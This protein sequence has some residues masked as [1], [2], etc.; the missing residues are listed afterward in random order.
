MWCSLVAATAF[1]FTA[2][3]AVN[4]W[5]TGGPQGGFIRSLAVDPTNAARIYAGTDAGV[6]SSTDGGNNWKAL[7]DG[8]AT[9]PNDFL[10]AVTALTFSSASIPVLYAAAGNR[11]F[12]TTAGASHWTATSAFHSGLG[13]DRIYALVT[14]PANPQ[15]IYAGV[16]GG[17]FKSLD[18]GSSW[19]LS[20][21]GFSC[22]LIYSLAVDPANPSNVYSVTCGGVYKSIDGGATWKYSNPG[23]NPVNVAGVAVDREHP[24]TIYAGTADGVFKSSDGAATWVAMNSGLSFPGPVAITT[25]VIDPS[26]AST[27]YLGMSTG[28]VFKSLDNAAS[29]TAFQA[30]VPDG[31]SALAVAGGAV[32][33]V[34]AGSPR[35]VLRSDDGAVWSSVNSGIQAHNVGAL[36]IDSAVVPAMYTVDASAGTVLKSTDLGASWSSTG[37]VAGGF[38]IA[39]AVDPSVPANVYAGT[40]DGVFKSTDGGSSWAG[41]GAGLPEDFHAGALAIAPSNP[42]TVYA[43]DTRFNSQYKSIDG[44]ASWTFM[45]SRPVRVIAIDPSNASTMYA[46]GGYGIYATGGYGVAKSIDGGA[47]WRDI[48]IGI[49]A[50]VLALAIDPTRPST[51]Y[52]STLDDGVFKS[53][54]GGGTW[55]AVNAGLPDP[56]GL[57]ID[58]L[59]I[60]PSNSSVLYVGTAGSGV[61]RTVSA[62][63]GWSSF[64]DGLNSPIVYALVISANG[65]SL[66]GATLAGVATVEIGSL[67]RRRVV[68]H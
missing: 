7:T 60:D 59:A 40:E 1:S 35:G 49:N 67:P 33:R 65:K 64:N 27:I 5:T 9:S 26:N 31:V 20:T 28:A 11:V 54:D 6:Y 53:V 51:L 15:T 14:D 21:N 56:R 62:G 46:S 45:G 18:G 2:S 12:R 24:S 36:A 4:R 63:A 55:V 8:L 3:A 43:S 13:S 57:E 22:Y 16:D 68:G 66:H 23:T 19:T 30:A 38:A 37:H 25:L 39:L 61:F 34:Y 50:Y 52:A 58:G 44:G 17:V 29:W 32:S 41:P 47:T 42:A 48:S 10:P